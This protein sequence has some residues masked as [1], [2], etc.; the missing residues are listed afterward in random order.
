LNCF[1]D[2]DESYEGG[3]ALFREPGD[4]GDVGAGVRDEDDK[5]E[6]ARPQT[7]PEAERQKVPAETPR[8]AMALKFFKLA[9]N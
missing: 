9:K 3:E 6:E 1:L 2:E 4:V 8:K 5:E 7:D